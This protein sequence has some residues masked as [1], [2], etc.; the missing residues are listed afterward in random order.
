MLNLR[1]RREKGDQGPNAGGKKDG[2]NGTWV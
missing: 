2:I 1:R